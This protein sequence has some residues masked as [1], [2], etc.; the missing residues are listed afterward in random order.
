MK[1]RSQAG[2]WGVGGQRAPEP[3]ASSSME[4]P[5]PTRHAHKHAI[6]PLKFLGRGVSVRQA[7][8][9]EV[10]IWENLEYSGTNRMIRS[11]VSNLATV[12]I[13]GAAFIVFS[14]AEDEK[15]AKQYLDHCMDTPPGRFD[16]KSFVDLYCSTR[17]FHRYQAGFDTT[18]HKRNI[19]CSGECCTEK[20]VTIEHQKDKARN[21]FRRDTAGVVFKGANVD[22]LC[23]E[24]FCNAK[25]KKP[26]LYK[27]MDCARFGKSNMKTQVYVT[28]A[29]FAVVAVNVALK[30]AAEFVV[31]HQK[32]HTV[33]GMS[34]ALA[35]KV[36]IAQFINTGLL[37]LILSVDFPVK[38]PAFGLTQHP[39]VNSIDAR[40]YGKYGASLVQTM[41]TNFCVAPF[42]HVATL[43]IRKIMQRI[44]RRSAVTQNQLNRIYVRPE[45][46][47]ASSYGEVLMGIATTLVYSSCMPIMLWVAFF[48]F[49]LKYWA[50]KWAIIHT[51]SKPPLYGLE[52]F[53]SFE[54]VM[55]VILA[56]HLVLAAFSFG[57]AGGTAPH[58]IVY[59]DATRFHM[60]PL[61]AGSFLVLL[62]FVLSAIFTHARARCKCK[63]FAKKS[64]GKVDERSPIN[65]HSAQHRLPSYVP[66]E[67]MQGEEVKYT[68]D[69]TTEP[70]FE[71][72]EDYEKNKSTLY[73]VDPEHGR[74]AHDPQHGYN[75]HK[76]NSKQYTVWQLT[77]D[78]F[79]TIGGPGLK[80]YFRVIRLCIIAFGL[81]AVIGSVQINSNLS[82]AKF[83][84]P[85]AQTYASFVAKTMLGM[86]RRRKRSFGAPA[87]TR[88]WA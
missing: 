57:T 68:V 84:R 22:A 67:A 31:Y 76:T 19:S 71:I 83:N 82:Q 10:I 63:C 40:W 12:L 35:I 21:C 55:Y 9:P 70:S 28:G 86:Y 32:E 39:T 4:E 79:V 29:T 48:G 62:A 3:D 72:A 44:Q 2:D 53:K 18:T 73:R 75:R 78:D 52:L 23:Y 20:L 87:W 5:E 16:N 88:F 60:I 50:D 61:W 1:P 56:L 26:S 69:W 6:L 45:L 58:D 81:S 51:Y 64:H 8:E 37:V 59:F 25:L 17:E 38:A 34:G 27:G 30:K 41:A 15:Q 42:S 66:N 77:E 74:V 11:V 46:N 47:I 7:P 65:A 49:L 36:F 80:Q 14:V 24:C 13:L 54:T 85:D 43:V 33:A